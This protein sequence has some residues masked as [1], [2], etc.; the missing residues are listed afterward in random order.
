MNRSYSFRSIASRNAFSKTLYLLH[1]E[2]LL[3]HSGLRKV[4]SN[5]NYRQYILIEI[6]L[7]VGIWLL[8]GIFYVSAV[9]LAKWAKLKTKRGFLTSQCTIHRPLCQKLLC[10][11]FVQWNIDWYFLE[12]CS[13]Q[14][15]LQVK[16]R[17]SFIHGFCLLCIQSSN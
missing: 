17:F 8:R 2:V 12:F 11:V 1:R 13:E 10:M 6:L 4:L 16:Y 3:K 9:G 5:N 15:R 14:T 7:L